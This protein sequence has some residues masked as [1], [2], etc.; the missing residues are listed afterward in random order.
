MTRRV[1]PA[2]AGSGPE[3]EATELSLTTSFSQVLPLMD[4]HSPTLLDPERV[5]DSK[6]RAQKP[7]ATY[8]RGNLQYMFLF[9]VKNTLTIPGGR[10]SRFGS[11]SLWLQCCCLWRFKAARRVVLGKR[12]CAHLGGGGQIAWHS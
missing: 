12:L 1:R 11:Y 9:I 5:N 2:T 10:S 3:P 7:A 6:R 8:D 4:E